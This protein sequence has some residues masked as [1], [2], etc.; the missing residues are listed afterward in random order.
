MDITWD[1]TSH[2]GVP[3][4]SPIP[5]SEGAAGDGSRPWILTPKSYFSLPPAF[6]IHRINFKS[7][8]MSTLSLV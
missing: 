6:K 2:T 1:A 5:T 7:N 8:N 4:L 3:G